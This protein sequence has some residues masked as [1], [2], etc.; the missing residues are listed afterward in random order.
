MIF[1]AEICGM[2]GEDRR[3][4]TISSVNPFVDVTDTPTS[5]QS[6]LDIDQPPKDEDK[7]TPSP[8]VEITS[9]TIPRKAHKV[10]TLT[11]TQYADTEVEELMA[12]LRETESLEEQGDILQYLVSYEELI[13]LPYQKNRRGNPRGIH[14]IP[15]Y[16][17]DFQG[18]LPLQ[19][20]TNQH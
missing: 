12:M 4:S 5:T 20:I 6:T 17:V 3:P 15:N 9:D 18:N 16:Y 2:A 8:E 10:R 19:K 1:L 11:E 7:R 14:V 13:D